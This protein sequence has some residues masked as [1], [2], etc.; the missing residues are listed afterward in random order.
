MTVRTSMSGVF[1]DIRTTG[2]DVLASLTVDAANRTLA[3]LSRSDV[4]VDCVTG[5]RNDSDKRLDRP[6]HPSNIIS[7]AFAPLLVRG[8]ASLE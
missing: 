1:G 2:P 6:P 4:E 3:V 5:A 7:D 8:Q